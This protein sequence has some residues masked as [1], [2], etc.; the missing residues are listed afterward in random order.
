M[1]IQ[2]GYKGTNY[3]GIYLIYQVIYCRRAQKND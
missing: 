3:M 1:P 2:Y